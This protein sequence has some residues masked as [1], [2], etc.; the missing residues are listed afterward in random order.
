MLAGDPSIICLVEEIKRGNILLPMIQRPFVWLN[1]E[2][3]IT[4]LFDSIIKKFP[5]GIF[6]FYQK[7]SDDRMA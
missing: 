2:E 7:S 3:R 1:D 6:L 5:I 4:K